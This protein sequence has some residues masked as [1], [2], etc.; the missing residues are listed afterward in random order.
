MI[1][2]LRFMDIE[3]KVIL[4]TGASEGIGAAC[5]TAFRARGARLSLTARSEPKLRAA[6]G[7]ESL[8][9]AGDI[10]DEQTRR[11][12]VDRTLERYGAI[13][14]LVNNAGMGMYAPSWRASMPD[15]RRLFELNLFAPLALTQLVVP[16]MRARRRGTIV[17]I[18][19]VAGKVTLPW[20][21]LYS[22]SKYAL[23]SWTDGLRMEL[24]ADG[25]H[26]MTVC[27]GYVKTGFQSHVLSG[28][29]P[30]KIL[31]G[32]RFA[33]TA[34]E[35]ALAIVRGVERNARTVVT[36]AGGWLF[37]L[38]ERL[39][40]SFVDARMAAVNREAEPAG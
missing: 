37:I 30:E 29:P 10:T 40:P 25:I 31:A 3:G 7:P 38:A 17:N 11:S 23:G 27:P 22:A 28:R 12:V 16:H 34:E 13:D 2:L 4:I 20:F 26:A 32:R 33:I 19:S 6:A 39:F 1:V 18:S 9:T 14:V 24:K 35:C 8:V 36:P 21:T 15:T 5:A